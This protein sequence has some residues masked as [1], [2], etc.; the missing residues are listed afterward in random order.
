MITL[1]TSA[2]STA[3]SVKHQSVYVRSPTNHN[4]VTRGKQKKVPLSIIKYSVKLRKTVRPF[5]ETQ[6]TRPA[7]V[8]VLLSDTLVA[9]SV[10]L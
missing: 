4:D 9:I 3:E 2:A 8:S 7:Y 10:A 6:N 1:I 5:T